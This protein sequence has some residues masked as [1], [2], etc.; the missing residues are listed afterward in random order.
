M[1]LV[2]EETV[3]SRVRKVYDRPT[4]PL[5]RVLAS[6]VPNPATTPALVALCTTASPLTLKRRIDRR[7]AA[8]PAALRRIQSA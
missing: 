5:A 8:M 7:L 4:T 2:C 1:K 6:G 3:G